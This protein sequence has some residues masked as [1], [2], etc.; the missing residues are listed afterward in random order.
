MRQGCLR[1][2]GISLLALPDI[3][4]L[5]APSDTTLPSEEVIMPL[6]SADVT[7]P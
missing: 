3:P 4:T 6:I 5:P 7:A 2:L 1:N